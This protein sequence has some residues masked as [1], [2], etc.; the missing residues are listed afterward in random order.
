[1]SEKVMTLHEVAMKLVGP[2]RPVGEAT[3]DTA[4]FNNLQALTALTESL[5]QEIVELQQDCFGS[6]LH[7]VHKAGECCRKFT[8][9]IRE[10]LTGMEKEQNNDR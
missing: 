2:V 1:M 4:R 3:S 6:H 5:L 9:H 10:W 7:S 8:V